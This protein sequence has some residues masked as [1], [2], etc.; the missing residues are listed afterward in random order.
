MRPVVLA[1][2]TPR[3]IDELAV[4][5]DRL[6]TRTAALPDHP[7]FAA[8]A[9]LSGRSD[10]GWF[11]RRYGLRADVELD[12]LLSYL[13]VLTH[14]QGETVPRLLARS[15]A[16]EALLAFDRDPYVLEQ[17]LVAAQFTYVSPF[18]LEG[19][20]AEYLFWYGGTERFYAEH[21]ALDARERARSLLSTLGLD[22]LEAVVPFV[23]RS[24]WGAWFDADSF[25]NA[26]FTVLHRGRR[27]A[28]M[29]CFTHRERPP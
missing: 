20:L 7:Y 18:L 4:E 15:S 21:S 2:G 1:A 17:S 8:I 3:S 11:A 27:E 26:T 13:Q 28:V 9:A 22:D 19:M 23:A 12:H 6:V 16:R 5:W 25:V 14:L 10:G 24:S 29:C